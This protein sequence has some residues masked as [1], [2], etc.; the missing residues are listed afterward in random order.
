MTWT[1]ERIW[2]VTD[3]A[4]KWAA[5]AFGDQ[6]I[7][8]CMAKLDAIEQFIRD[9]GEDPQRPGLGVV[10]A[11]QP[12]GNAHDLV[13]Q[14]TGNLHG[15]GNRAKAIIKG[16]KRANPLALRWHKVALEH[17]LSHEI[18]KHVDPQW[19]PASTGDVSETHISHPSVQGAAP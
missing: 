16:Y 7:Q 19:S 6:L 14:I 11:C 8:A 15:L 17:W 2:T 4:C 18:G 12:L 13:S 1:R 5:Q 10:Y 3:G 9:A